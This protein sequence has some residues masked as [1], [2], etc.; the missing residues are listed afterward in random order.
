MQIVTIF[1]PFPPIQKQPLPYRDCGNNLIVFLCPDLYDSGM[2]PYPVIQKRVDWRAMLAEH[3][4]DLP[5]STA[6]QEDFSEEAR[7]KRR[8]AGQF[9]RMIEPSQQL[10]SALQKYQK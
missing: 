1:L 10:D 5:P 2:D 6:P 9:K 8:L 4:F 7:T 3:F